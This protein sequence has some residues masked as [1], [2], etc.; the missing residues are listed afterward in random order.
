MLGRLYIHQDLKVFN[1]LA[2]LQFS[3]K[4][5]N[6]GTTLY[7]L[8]FGQLPRPVKTKPLYFWHYCIELSRGFNRE[9]HGIRRRLGA[10]TS[11]YLAQ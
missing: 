11:E 1:F 6:W 4:K 7:T 3:E 9:S 8:I 10:V 2:E 5:I